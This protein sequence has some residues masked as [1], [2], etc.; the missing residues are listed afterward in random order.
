M[1]KVWDV[2][3]PKKHINKVEQHRVSSENLIAVLFSRGVD[4]QT[5][6]GQYYAME[7]MGNHGVTLTVAD[8]EIAGLASLPN[9]PL[10]RQ[11]F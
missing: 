1:N 9:K 3:R 7:E 11:P 8:A 6:F 2:S 4:I 5:I 10:P